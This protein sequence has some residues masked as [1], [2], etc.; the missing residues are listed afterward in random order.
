MRR[1]QVLARRNRSL[2]SH[3]ADLSFRS[4]SGPA[5]RLLLELSHEVHQP[6]DLRRHP[7]AGL[8]A[9]ITTVLEA[10]SRALQAFRRQ[11]AISTTRT[12]ILVPDAAQLRRWGASVPQARRSNPLPSPS[13]RGRSCPSHVTKVNDG[14]PG[15]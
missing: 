8:A 13:G 15:L 11:A 9:R 3:V 5:A 10:L 12:A 2:L 7:N 1:L 4:V 6:I 14:S